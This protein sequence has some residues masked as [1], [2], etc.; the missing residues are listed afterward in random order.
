MLLSVYLDREGLITFTFLKTLYA[1]GSVLYADMPWCAMFSIQYGSEGAAS[2]G[3]KGAVHEVPR[4]YA[5]PGKVRRL[6]SQDAHKN[7]R[8]GSIGRAV[9]TSRGGLNEPFIS[10]L[11]SSARGK[12][13]LC[14]FQEAV[15]N[16][17]GRSRMYQPSW[18]LS[19]GLRSLKYGPAVRSS[20]DIET[21][22]A[23][24]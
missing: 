3:P 10:A 20:H 17:D 9:G 7:G 11:M 22:R 19:V 1:E 2:P 18:V 21:N 5:G 24:G 6:K 13:R 8:S 12:V 4:P 14:K 15:R 23:I 16:Q